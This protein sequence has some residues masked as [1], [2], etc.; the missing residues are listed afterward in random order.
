MEQKKRM[1]RKR[2]RREEKRMKGLGAWPGD[3]ALIERKRSQSAWDTP[4]SF[5]QKA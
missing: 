4:G 3:R 1:K 5:T 2:E